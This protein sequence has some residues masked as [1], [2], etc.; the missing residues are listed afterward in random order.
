M[1]PYY[2]EKDEVHVFLQRRSKTA[3]R[4]PDFFGFFGGGL[5]KDEKPIDALKREIFEELGV[6]TG[7]VRFFCRYEFFGSVKNVYSLQVSKDFHKQIILGEG[8]YGKYFTRDEIKHESKLIEEDKL[9]LN[10]F[11]DK[12]EYGAPFVY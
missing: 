1:I 11:F 7:E 2:K 4:L 9:V 3:K 12:E 8:Q 5:E 10:N 6:E